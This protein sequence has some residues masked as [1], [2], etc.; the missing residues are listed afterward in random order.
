[1]FDLKG[2]TKM[3]RF[4]VSSWLFVACALAANAAMA[5]MGVVQLWEGGPYW[6]ESNLG[7]S[8]VAGHPETGTAYGPEL[9]NKMYC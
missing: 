5:A 3:K 4:A 2:K 7:E 9:C 1:M 6:A 8:E